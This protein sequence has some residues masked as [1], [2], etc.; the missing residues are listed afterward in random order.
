MELLSSDHDTQVD[1]LRHALR[2]K[3]DARPTKRFSSDIPI[4]TTPHDSDLPGL[5]SENNT[6]R[7]MLGSLGRFIGEGLLGGPLQQMGVSRDELLEMINGRSEKTMTDAWQNWPGAKEVSG[8]VGPASSSHSSHLANA[9]VLRPHRS[10]RPCDKSAKMP[11]FQQKGFL[12]CGIHPG[13]LRG[14]ESAR[15]PQTTHAL[16]PARNRMRGRRALRV[17]V[18]RMLGQTRS[19][20]PHSP[21]KKQAAPPAYNRTKRI[22]KRKGSSNQ[23]SQ[24][25][26]SR[27]IPNYM[28]TAVKTLQIHRIMQACC[29]RPT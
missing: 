19:R 28:P 10:A 13:P 18:T 9:D 4:D 20:G 15:R 29:N 11:T 2:G 21:N 23:C 3:W 24:C 7:A 14:E 5:L 22:H 27:T 25:H 16:A 12:I 1:R 26:N 17:G 8:G 6:L